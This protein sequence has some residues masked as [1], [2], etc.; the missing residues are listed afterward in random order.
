MIVFITNFLK[1]LS[2]IV[3]KQIIIPSLY[4]FFMWVSL[5]AAATLFFAD[6]W[7][8]A[9]FISALSLYFII[10]SEFNKEFF[11]ARNAVQKQSQG[12]NL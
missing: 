12:N 3:W 6:F 9:G 11:G 4:M 2:K 8:G 5:V 10:Q 7:R 1:E